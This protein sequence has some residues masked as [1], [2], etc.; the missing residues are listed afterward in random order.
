MKEQE[1]HL[2][3]NIL[4][5]LRLLQSRGIEIYQLDGD[6]ALEV[7]E[8]VAEYLQ[9]AREWVQFMD[10]MPG[11]FLVYCADAREEIIYANRALLQ[12]FQCGTMAEFRARTGNSFRGLVHP[13]DLERVE[14]SIQEQIAGSRSDL[15]YVEYRIQR[16]DGEV[17]W[18]EDY[19]HYV[20]TVS[21]GGIFY[22]FISDATEKREQILSEKT[23][24]LNQRR[25][26][27][28]ELKSL[29]L[30][31]NEE[32]NL[33]GQEQKR[34]LEIIEGL[35]VNYDSICYVDLEQD[36][37]KPYRMSE[38]AAP[39]FKER[40]E[41]QKYSWFS[42]TYVKTWVH[43]E[44]REV[45]ARA[46]APDYIREQFKKSGTYYLN[47]RAVVQ[48]LPQYLQ[49]RLVNAGHRTDTTQM[50]L[51][52]RRVDEEIQQQL[53]QKQL[54]ADALEKANLA[55]TAKNT[56]LSNMSH[57][58]RTPLNAIFGFTS[59]AKLDLEQHDAVY[60]YLEKIETAG[61]RLLDM[62]DKVLEVAALSNSDCLRE[63]E[64]N[65]CS[66]IGEVYDF[67]L[68][69]AQEKD[70]DFT[71]DCV[72]VTH[73]A[74]FADQEKLKQLVMYLANNAITYTNAGG[75]VEI[76]LREVEELPNQ[77]VIFQLV[78][79]DTGIGISQEFLARAFEPFSR[80]KNSTLSGIHGIGLGLSIAKS[81]VDMMGGTI[82]VQSVVGEGSVFTAN[83]RFRALP[84]P[85]LVMGEGRGHPL[86]VQKILLVEDNEINREIETELLEKLGFVIDTA[87]N[88]QIALEK[89]QNAA[90]GDYDLI[91]MDLQMP[92]MDGWQASAE[93]R[94]LPDP[95]LARIPIIALSANVLESDRRRSK[96]CG[97]DVH[98]TKPLDLPLL[99]KT[100]DSVMQSR[101]SF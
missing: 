82:E 30:A 52:Y 58:M 63:V 29:R 75:T 92:V 5:L 16:K 95:A 34:R 57:D 91:L 10:E 90:P 43:P 55:M 88:G 93:I 87:E 86:P 26:N 77:Y 9:A 98:L 94:S 56:F 79:R 7:P 97:V 84:A 67:L 60:E 45:V 59:L 71:L 6:G 13:D 65:F 11:G 28:E 22:V 51:G 27:E 46:T 62:I 70:I 35:S 41:E 99:I 42:D 68:P 66:I 73:C 44:D 74:V 25:K 85:G 23:A 76:C 18:I 33:S 14:T 48:G 81:I 53:E 61:H 83:L 100:I 39:L 72:E 78:V 19:G 8:N 69:Q 47:Y 89:M 24:L 15:D 80:E 64:C 49:L 17:R 40:F 1:R 2:I 32:R 4:C 50:V 96:E 31:Y 21:M 36:I 3:E 54:L 101:R 20:D 37:I 12:I 38:R